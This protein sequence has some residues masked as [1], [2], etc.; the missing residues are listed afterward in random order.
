MYKVQLKVPFAGASI[1]PGVGY[2]ILKSPETEKLR[3]KRENVATRLEAVTGK[4]PTWHKR[5]YCYR[6]ELT[7]EEVTEISSW[8]YVRHVKEIE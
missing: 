4:V 3:T 5:E 6:I 8:E 1:L 2:D 7:P